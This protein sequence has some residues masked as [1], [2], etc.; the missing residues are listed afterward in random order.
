[1][2]YGGSGAAGIELVVTVLVLIELE[3][4]LILLD[5]GVLLLITELVVVEL[6]Q[7]LVPTPGHVPQPFC[8]TIGAPQATVLAAGQ[9]GG[10]GLHSA[11][12][13]PGSTQV[14]HAPQGV[15]VVA[16]PSLTQLRQPGQSQ[17]ERLITQASIVRV[18]QSSPFEQRNSSPQAQALGA[19]SKNATAN[20]KQM[21]GRIKLMF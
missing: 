16:V 10:M 6:V 7:F 8:E 2:Q 20:T 1:M 11:I 13:F 3:L 15:Q 4:L 14:E 17:G 21:T 18:L 5:D 9:T 12:R 19:G